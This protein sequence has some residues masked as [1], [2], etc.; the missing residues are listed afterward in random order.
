MRRTSQAIAYI[1]G[2]GLTL[3]LTACS[4]SGEVSA[5]Q[6][7]GNGLEKTTLKVG[8]LPIPDPAALFIA[9]AKG[10]F[11]EE[12][13]EVETSII[14][15]GAAA[16]PKIKNGS[17]D[18]SQ[19]NYVSTFL[20]V[21]KGE[22]IKLIADAYQAAPNTFNLMVPK[23]S[24][25]RTAADLK[26]KTVAVNTLT[27]IGTLAVTATLK[28]AGLKADDVTFK[29]Y[30]F[31]EM[32]AALTQGQVD[33]AWVTEPFIT[34]TQSQFGFRKLADTM[35]GQ[36]AD[37]PI[38]GWMATD[39]FAKNNPKT[40]AAFQRALAK[41]QQLA[42]NDR[43]EVEA[44]VPTYTSIKQE[45]AA[46]ITLG[47]FPTTLNETRLQRVADLMLEYGYLTGKLDVKTLL[48]GAST[49]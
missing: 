26:G 4:G 11:K 39:E 23:D 29:E 35:T 34:A 16:L 47:T 46:V 18:I 36:T 32:G 22:K 25:I 10:F 44:I 9:K 40:L 5:G 1:A 14:A 12:G 31:P 38:A 49:P 28:V 15:G 24:P 33:A 43:K 17:L 2:L 13:L 30:P 3:A 21:S 8:A 7:S 41:G 19:T 20:A 45:T 42:A 6:A 27:N 37:L 48:A